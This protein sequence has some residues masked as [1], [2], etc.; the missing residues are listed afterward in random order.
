[1]RMLWF[2]VFQIEMLALGVAAIY[3]VVVMR[4]SVIRI[5]GKLDGIRRGLQGEL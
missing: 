5:E 4:R 1:M 3:V 2:I